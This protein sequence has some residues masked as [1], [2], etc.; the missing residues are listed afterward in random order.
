M[1]QVYLM[2]RIE[3]DPRQSV[4]QGANLDHVNYVG[5]HISF[6]QPTMFYDFYG[7]ALV[8]LPC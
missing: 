6:S 4:E 5:F 1:D 8:G 3:A 2:T 7:L